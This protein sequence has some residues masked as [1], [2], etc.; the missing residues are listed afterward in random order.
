MLLSAVADEVC[1]IGRAWL[2]KVE[3]CIQCCLTTLIWAMLVQIGKLLVFES[4]AVKLQM[5]DVLMDVTAGTPCQF[6]QE[7]AAVNAKDAHFIFLGDV[8]QRIVSS[9]NIEQLIK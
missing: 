5:G 7:I 8:S 9:P 1:S 4:G 2:D 6:R 3:H